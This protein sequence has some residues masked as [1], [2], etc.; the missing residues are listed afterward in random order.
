MTTELKVF[1]PGLYLA[2]CEPG[3]SEPTKLG[4]FVIPKTFTAVF[5]FK[6]FD[7]QSNKLLDGGDWYAFFKISISDLGTPVLDGLEIT[8]NVTRHKIRL[9]EQYRYTLL[10]LALQIVVKTLTPSYRDINEQVFNEKY[11]KKLL[12]DGHIE[13]NASN[14]D[15]YL[16]QEPQTEPPNIVRW[17]DSNTDHLTVTEL[18]QLSKTI[19]T[20]LRKRITPEYLQHI[21]ELYTQ[22]VI[23][24]KKPIQAIMDSEH[25]AHRTASEYASK[26]R[27]LELLPDT[28]PGVIT[29]KQPTRK[30]GK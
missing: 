6:D 30:K 11:Y 19:N 28:V 29:I 26:A 16:N 14:W 27:I 21:A 9:I 7:K 25:V 22:A 10:E 8:K 13:L 2:F 1:V 3:Q 23:D 18:K 5:Q 24:G 4:K 17:W 15:E 20:R 12:K